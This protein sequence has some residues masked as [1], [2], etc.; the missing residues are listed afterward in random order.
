MRANIAVLALVIALFAGCSTMK[1]ESTG[2]EIKEEPSK[3][4]KAGTTTREEVIKS[5]G[6]PSKATKT[7]G[8]EE[9]VYESRKEE[10]PVYLG[11]L[12]I[13]ESGKSITA[14]R[15]VVVIEKGIVR[16]YKYEAKVE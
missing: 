12:V 5:F 3:I 10:T 11:G 15:L 8:S 1:V 14:K 2:R 7:E 6:E 9:L 4:I 13:G 16:S